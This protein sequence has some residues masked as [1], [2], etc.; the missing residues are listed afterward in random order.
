MIIPVQESV[1][2][3]EIKVNEQLPVKSGS[4]ERSGIGATLSVI[5][6]CCNWVEVFPLPSSNVQVME[7]VPC[8][9][10]GKVEFVVP[11]IAPKQLLV[12]V[13]GVIVETAHGLLRFGKEDASGI[14]GSD[15]IVKVAE[16]VCPTEDPLIETIV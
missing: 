3:G 9:E 6:T 1:A 5:I 4:V 8:V 2:V 11:V 7:V 10:I 15:K 12:A 16:P 13:G 14:G